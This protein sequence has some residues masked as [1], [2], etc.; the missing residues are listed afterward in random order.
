MRMRRP[1]AG[2]VELEGVDITDAAVRGIRKAGVDLSQTAPGEHGLLLEAPL[3]GEHDPGHQTRP[4]SASRSSPARPPRPAQ[5]VEAFLRRADAVHH[6]H[7][8]S[9]SGGNQQKLIIGRG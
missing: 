7:G 9:L 1:T 8:G 5:I 2:T 3:V 6:G 4:Q